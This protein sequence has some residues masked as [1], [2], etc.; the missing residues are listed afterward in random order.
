MTK[1][2]VRGAA[3]LSMDSH[4]GDLASGDILIDGDSISAIAPDLGAPGAQVIEAAGMIALPGFVNTHIHTWQTG[5]RG[6]AADWTLGEYL[7]AMHAG[8]ATYFSPEDI[9]IANELGALHQIHAGTTTLAD[10][11]H[12][13][14]TPAHTDAA[15]AGLRAAGIRAVFLHGSPKPDPRP[16]QPHFSEVPMPRTEVER[17]AATMAG[18]ALVTLGLAILGPQMSVMGVTETDL[19]LA[20]ELGVLASMHVS[21]PLMTP[22]AFER[23]AA[24]G[25]L[26]SHINIVHGNA[27]SDAQL[28]I[29]TGSDASFSMTPEVE[30]QMGFGTPLMR[31][32][33]ERGGHIALG[34]DIESG[35]SGDMFSATRFALQAARHDITLQARAAT[36]VPPPKM[37]ISTREAL[38]WAT[39]GGARM[40]RL[41]DRIGSLA[42]GKQADLILIDARGIN[43]RPVHDPAASTLFHAG[44]RD[45]DTVMIA[46]H[47][48]KRGGK[49][50][51]TGLDSMLDRLEESGS[52]I[53][54]EFRAG[55]GTAH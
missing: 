10:W 27:L 3:I 37:D 18:D 42:P 13:N 7:R 24:Q 53:M 55:K 44:P 12:N 30:L 31:R 43:M 48:K 36:G 20:R 17:L 45:V 46:G 9:G 34:T 32:V 35:M 23:L 15:V 49:L 52:R 2:L 22:D 39:I 28:D 8:L 29:L 47:V 54:A 50:I 11:C 26:G 51:A 21:G 40:L 14:P 5:L 16:G 25:L 6:I 19:R 41:D 38:A 4:I 33:R 1:T